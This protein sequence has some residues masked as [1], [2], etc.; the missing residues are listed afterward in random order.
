MKL[1]YYIGIVFLFFQ[2]VCE[3]QANNKVDTVSIDEEAYLKQPFFAENKTIFIR[4][5]ESS[6]GF[7]DSHIMI[8]YGAGKT[9]FIE[10]RDSKE[11]RSKINTIRIHY[12]LAKLL[13]LGYTVLNST[14]SGSDNMMITTYLLT[15]ENG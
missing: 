9:E 6:T 11:S 13:S 3:A 2:V 1:K 7:K 4:V 10:M 12:I 14:A 8:S 15:K 5:Y